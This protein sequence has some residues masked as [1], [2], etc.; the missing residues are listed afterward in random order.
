MNI[1][2]FTKLKGPQFT[3]KHFKFHY[4]EFLSYINTR[5]P[6]VQSFQERLYWYVHNL[7]CAPKCRCGADVVFEG[8]GKGY[9]KYCS[10]ACMNSD[11]DKKETVKSTCVQRYGGSAPASSAGVM[12][13]MKSTCL[14]RYGVDNAMKSE[15]IKQKVMNII[16]TVYGGVGNAADSIRSKQTQTLV[17][18]YGTS[19]FNNRDK[20]KLTCLERYG[21]E[22]AQSSDDIKKSISK[23]RARYVVNK[24]ENV[25]G[26]NSN[27]DWVCACPHPNCN[28][29]TEKSYIISGNRYRDRVK[30]NTE[31]CTVL[32]PVASSPS[33]TTIELFIRNVLDG[34]GVNYLTNVRG[35]IGRQEIDIYCPELK[36]G[37]ECNGD[38]W[39]STLHKS[40]SYHS[41]KTDT[42]AQNDITLYHVW[43]DWIVS[44]PDIISSMIKNWV[45]CTERTIYARK[46]MIK[47]VDKYTCA[48]FLNT[49]HIQGE[50]GCTV[51]YGLYYN[52]ELVSLMSF[53]R[54]NIAMRGDRGW[55][56]VRF[57]SSLN[58]RVVG[59]AGK[60]LKHFIINHLP[61][62][63]Y[64]FASRDISS[65]N[66]YKKLGFM[67]DGKVTSSYW[68]INPIT[69]QR[70]HRMSFTKDKI[71][72]LGWKPNK[73]GWTES[74]V[75]AEHG[76]LK[77]CD[78]GQTKWILN[79]YVQ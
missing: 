15:P 36:I 30:D 22:H 70:Y 33:G 61:S 71:V 24:Y 74:Q 5:Y 23:G 66:L 63:I 58:T 12:Q 16:T 17:L 42:A 54:R 29:C 67:S 57:C 49:N 27:G 48:Q 68:Y 62:S 50:A 11:P 78:A 37:I 60:L 13:K 19:S 14:K 9:R 46:C 75:M 41:N 39:H 47:Q 35:L 2:D 1:P 10:R 6:E 4:P 43:E 53:G 20:C 45:G 56:L 25:L 8:F 3:E 79:C 76:F 55:E 77:I 52:G 26:V 65:G 31:P 18:R 73:E 72:Q 38:F 51:A 44:K 7:S 40:P 21:F 28:K 69:M 59:G 34:C 32:R 64:S